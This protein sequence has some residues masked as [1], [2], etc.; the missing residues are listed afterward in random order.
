MNA[1][2]ATTGTAALLAQLSEFVPDD[3][4]NQL[5]PPQRGR[6]RRSLW[7]SAQLFRLVLL[8]LLPPA[9]SF[10]L[11]VQLLPEQRAWRRFAH[12]P[13]RRRVPTASI[14]HEFRACLGVGSLRRINRHLLLPLLEGLSPE[15][16]SVA[17]IYSTDLPAA[18]STYK[19]S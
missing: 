17:L 3:F 16:K 7:S 5:L 4:I 15:R 14:L 1:P 10:D 11:L 19:K 18:T 12:L 2:L 9:R 8:A 6:G 13:N